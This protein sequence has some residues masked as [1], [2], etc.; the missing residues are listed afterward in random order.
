MRTRDTVVPFKELF[1]KIIDHETFFLHNEK[2]YPDPT[3]PTTNLAKTSSSSYCPTKSLSPSS[4]LGLL[5]NPISANKQYKP[6]N[7]YNSNS[8]SVVCQFCSKPSHDAKRCFKLF[9]QLRS[10]RL[11]T[12]HVITSS[13]APTQWI[14]DS[15]ASHHVTSNMSNLFLH[16]PYEGPDDIQIGDGSGSLYEDT[17]TSRKE[18]A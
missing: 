18:L 5:P 15:G 2:Q 7:S 9:P 1:D 13:S 11:F 16:Q 12:N 4:T 6:T 8:N 14:V 10:Q 17:S 3:P